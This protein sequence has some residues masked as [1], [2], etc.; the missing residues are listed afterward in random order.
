MTIE[1]EQDLN[2]LREVGR[3]VA[4][5]L[6]HMHNCVEPGMTTLELDRIGGDLLEREG[7]RSAPQL[8]YEFPGFTCISI[9]EEAAHGIPGPR[10][11]TAGDV[12]NID[13]SAEKNGYFADT[14]GTCVVP[15]GSSVKTRLLRATQQALKNAASAARAEQPINGIGRA[16]QKVARRTG[17]RTIRNLAGHGV[18]RG[19]H[20]EP[21]E[22]HNYFE[23]RDRRVLREGMVLAVEPFLSTRARYVDE[24]ED[25]WTLAAPAGNLSAQFEH[26]LVVTRGRPIFLTLA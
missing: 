25:G 21:R 15:P 14:G 17:F 4:T 7:A 22:I 18:G 23:P 13:V 16:I 10:V 26:T 5:T 20:E 19:L 6:K 2:A 9:N 8:T 11:I 24:L 12:V 1:S 3:I